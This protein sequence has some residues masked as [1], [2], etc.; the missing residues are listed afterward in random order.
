MFRDFAKLLE[1]SRN[2]LAA[3]SLNTP[4]E[5]SLHL[6]KCSSSLNCEQ[7]SNQNK[8]TGP[9]AGLSASA[10]IKTNTP[11]WIKAPQIDIPKELQI[12]DVVKVPVKSETK[13][14]DTGI[15]QRSETQV[16]LSSQ[17]SGSVNG[18]QSVFKRPKPPLSSNTTPCQQVCFVSWIF[19]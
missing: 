10:K 15:S 13:T 5:L 12:S 4:S 6:S 3:R 1:A 14:S 11:T 18:R 2:P 16:L 7:E 9:N 19:V 8:L 17:R